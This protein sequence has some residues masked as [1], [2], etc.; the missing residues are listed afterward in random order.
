MRTQ[1]IHVADVARFPQGKIAVL[2]I[3]I[4]EIAAVLDGLK[5]AGMGER[6]NGKKAGRQYQAFHEFSPLVAKTIKRARP[7]VNRARPLRKYRGQV[8]LAQADNVL[9]QHIVALS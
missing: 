6:R 9:C 2:R 7:R 5:I 3:Q 8:K 4:D 1:R